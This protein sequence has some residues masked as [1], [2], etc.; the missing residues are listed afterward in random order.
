LGAE[1]ILLP[2][3]IVAALTIVM[4]IL[5]VSTRIPAMTAAGIDAQD[6][7][8]TSALGGRL[9][10]RVEFIADNYNHLFEQPTVFYA[11]AI[12]IAVLGHTDALHVQ[13]AWAFAILRILHSIVQAT[14]NIVLVRFGLFIG[15]WIAIAIMVVREIVALA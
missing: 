11:V 3:F 15:A 10:A 7:Q 12:S 5:M 8:R 4:M 6:A 1:A 13:C 2:V 14:A 9:P